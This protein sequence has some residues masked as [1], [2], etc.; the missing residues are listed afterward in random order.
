[1]AGQ[2][3][4][5]SLF[6]LCVFASCALT[7]QGASAS[8]QTATNV[9]AVTCV[10]GG[11]KDFKD[12]HCKDSVAAGAGGFGH[13]SIKA[14]EKTTADV[15]NET[16][17]GAREPAVLDGNLFG[18][19]AKITCQK[20][21]TGAGESY[22]L[23]V[24]GGDVEGKT[25]VN[26]TECTVT[27][28]GATCKVKE[29]IELNAKVTAQREPAAEA[30]ALQFLP[31][32]GGGALTTIGF[33]GGCIVF[34]TELKGQFRGTTEGATLNVKPEDDELTI[35]GNKGTLTG[36]ITAKMV[37]GGNPISLARA[38]IT[39]TT[40]AKGGTKDF[41]DAHCK[42]GAVGGTGEFGHVPIKAGEKTTADVSN[43][44]TGGAR[45]PAVLNGSLFGVALK[46]TCQK[47]ATG[48]GES[49]LLNVEGGD[50]EGRTSINL[51][52]CTVTGNGAT[53]KVKEPIQLNAKVNAQEDFA[54]EGVALRYLPLVAGGA[55][56]TIGFEGG[57]LLF[58]TE[59]KGQFRGTA[60]GATLNFK[61]EDE[62]LTAFGSKITLTEKFTAKMAGGGNPLSFT[63]SK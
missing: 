10:E 50:V 49:Y 31:L 52:E 15:S 60:E 47:V 43:E 23:N 22:L 13:V 24:E 12:A 9:T 21:A 26:L 5:R 16:T 46:W 30:V 3:S 19:A 17:G 18:V 59:L 56:A 51:T 27:G 29:P 41:K 25:S 48:A 39:A 57:C 4:R 33:E 54:S 20:V 1:M 42:E 37:G 55:F 63:T 53:C 7:T 40:C 6:L 2:K 44:T 8:W 32:V 62:E 58:S 36:K 38:R 11:T 45:E 34:S 14:G 28:N 35:F 61:P